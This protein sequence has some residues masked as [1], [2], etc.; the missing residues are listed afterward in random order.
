MRLVALVVLGLF[1]LCLASTAVERQA[2]QLD[3]RSW[4]WELPAD[5]PL[6][7]DDLEGD[8]LYYGQW[9]SLKYYWVIP[10]PDGFEDTYYNV[11]FTPQSDDQAV[12][13]LGALIPLYDLQGRKGTPSLKVLVWSTGEIAGE[14]GYPAE[15]IDSLIVPYE[16]LLFSSYQAGQLTLRMNYVDLSRLKISFGS[17]EE[18]HIGVD[19]MDN[20]GSDQL[21]IF[22]DTGDMEWATDRSVLWD[23]SNHAWKKMRDIEYGAP[24]GKRPFNLA[25]KAVV[26]YGRVDVPVVL[27]PNG[28]QPGDVSIA[29]C[30][31]NPFNSF[32]TVDYSVRPG[33]PYTVRLLGRDGRVVHELTQGIGNGRQTYILKGFALPAGGY[34]LEVKT[35]QASAVTNIIY[36]K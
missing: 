2:R 16:D 24:V 25:I 35:G 23:G 18:F 22:S 13:L 33:V 17:A 20:T 34:L 7:D 30:Y 10:E 6:R 19:L 28:L 11:R 1:S 29:G 3:V 21:S 14:P 4:K 27:E 32:T 8:T 9:D 15:L 26:S 5:S 36:L 31:P 12:N